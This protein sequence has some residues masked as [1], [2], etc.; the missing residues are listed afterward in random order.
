MGKKETR[1]IKTEEG[2]FLARLAGRDGTSQS[3]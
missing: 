1:S 3:S 2:G